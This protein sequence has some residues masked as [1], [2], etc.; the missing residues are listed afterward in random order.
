ELA[1]SLSL[2]VFVIAGLALTLAMGTFVEAAHGTPAAQ[3]GVYQTWWFNC[4]LALL[5]I[6]IFF[7]AAI[8]YPWKRHQ[9]GFVITHIGIL[10]LLLGTGLSRKYGIDAQIMVWEFG[11]NAWAME[12]K[13]HFRLMEEKQVADSADPHSG[14]IAVTNLRPVAFDPGPFSWPD[15]SR[16]FTLSDLPKDVKKDDDAGPG[17]RFFRYVSGWMYTIAGSHHRGE[18]LYNQ[19]GVKLEVLEYYADSKR[20]EGPEVT[21]RVSAPRKPKIGEDGKERWPPYRWMP[22]TIQVVSVARGGDDYPYGINV[23]KGRFPGGSATLTTTDQPERL[24]AFLGSA[25][26]GPLG[27]KGQVVLWIDGKPRRIS[28]DEKLGAGRFAVDGT[29]WEVEL[30]DYWPAAQLDFNA[31]TKRIEAVSA[32]GETDSVNPAVQL[33]MFRDDK[34]A[35]RLLLFSDQPGVSIHDCQNRIYGDY[36]FDHAKKDRN[37][38]FR[39]GI[40][41]RIDLLQVKDA[42]GKYALYYRRWDKSGIADKGQI[43]SDGSPATAKNAFAMDDQLK[44]YVS[45]HIAGDV[46]QRPESSEAAAAPSSDDIVVPRP[47]VKDRRIVLREPAVKVRLT[48]D[49]VASEHWINANKSNPNF[50]PVKAGPERIELKGKDRTVALVLTIDAIDVGVRVRLDDFDRR[51]DPGTSQPSHYSSMID[52]VGRDVDRKI[53]RADFDGKS[54]HDV[55]LSIQLPPDAARRADAIAVAKDGQRIFWIDQKRRSIYA[56]PLSPPEQSVGKLD[57]APTPAEPVAVLDGAKFPVSPVALAIDFAGGRLV[58]IEY[59]S[60]RGGE[61][62]RVRRVNLEDIPTDD[63]MRGGQTSVDQAAVETVAAFPGKA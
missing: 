33:Q 2:A 56:A 1:G 45:A 38:R 44:F 21:V 19:G 47:F 11:T 13:M 41:N 57:D 37:V 49:G 26:A 63:K 43:A 54:V 32:D 29:P 50:L 58:W 22:Q 31:E 12:D 18:T 17:M 4:L 5:A 52:L 6:N 39:H 8:R 9:T 27:E 28:V 7:A 23:S 34:P 14:Q 20:V 36:W 55:P 40:G 10:V 24:D 15:Y 62:S 16:I 3:F 35:G 46:P 51:L 30:T 61:V 48:V 25:P 42:A 59:V 60:G 53:V